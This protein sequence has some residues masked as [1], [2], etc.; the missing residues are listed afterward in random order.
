MLE[1]QMVA[2]LLNG[3]GSTEYHDNIMIGE[4][5]VRRTEKSGIPVA[6]DTYIES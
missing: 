1:G 6:M 2:A 3:R 4:G 5:L